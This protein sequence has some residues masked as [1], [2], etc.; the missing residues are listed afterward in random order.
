M[1][2]KPIETE[3]DYRKAREEIGGIFDA[4]PNTP[5]GDYLDSLIILV[6]KYEDDLYPI[7]T[8]DLSRKP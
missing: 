1:D 8:L 4:K 6:E 2:I 5:D 3:K 7:Q